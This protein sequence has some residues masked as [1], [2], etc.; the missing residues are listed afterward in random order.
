[1][2][3][4]PVEILQWMAPVL[5]LFPPL[6]Q[7]LK[8][9]TDP[10]KYLEECKAEAEKNFDSQ[11]YD[12]AEVVLQR[13]LDTCSDLLSTQDSCHILKQMIEAKMRQGKALEAISSCLL[14]M[15]QF[16]EVDDFYRKFVECYLYADKHGQL[17]YQ[18]LSLLQQYFGEQ[19]C[20]VKFNR[21]DE[22]IFQI[23]FDFFDFTTKRSTIIQTLFKDV[24]TN[25]T[26][27]D[28]VAKYLKRSLWSKSMWL[29]TM[30]SGLTQEV[31]KIDTILKDDDIPEDTLQDV[32]AKV[33]WVTQQLTGGGSEIPIGLCQYV[34]GYSEIAKNYEE[35]CKDEFFHHDFNTISA[36]TRKLV[37]RILSE[38]ENQ[39][40]CQ[41][42]QHVKQLR[43]Q[44]PIEEEEEVSYEEWGR[45]GALMNY[46]MKTFV[47]DENREESMRY[48]ESQGIS[49]EDL[50]ASDIMNHADDPKSIKLFFEEQMVQSTHDLKAYIT[51]EG[52]KR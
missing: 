18:N 8:R 3:I 37:S 5:P 11:N 24:I 31:D 50:F 9:A 14:A 52:H 32:T 16:P 45:R 38:G 6:E 23:L 46:V 22:D 30:C 47:P 12:Q 7:Q 40:I 28:Q 44:T 21:T 41:R 48:L 29:N 42:V 51:D 17:F 49:I 20:Y 19:T 27:R 13:I 25:N 39:G 36:A 1:M 26:M 43:Q 2:I 33:R 34:Q 4:L 10:K 35:H 15:K